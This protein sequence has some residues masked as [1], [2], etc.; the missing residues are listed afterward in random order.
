MQTMLNRLV[1]YARAKNL[2]IDTVTVSE[3][4]HSNS[5]HGA[6][7]PTFMSASAALSALT[8]FSPLA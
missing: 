3:V 5:K 4:V 8:R 1:V 6:Q 2:T 7:V